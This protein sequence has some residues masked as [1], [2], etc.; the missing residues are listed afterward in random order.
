[1]LITVGLFTFL[2]FMFGVAAGTYWKNTE[3]KV[4]KKN[5]HTEENGTHFEGCCEPR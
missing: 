5:W 3:I 1:M 2:V 4:A